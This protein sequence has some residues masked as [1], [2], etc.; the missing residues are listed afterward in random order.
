MMNR[1]CKAGLLT[2][3]GVT[4][5]AGCGLCGDRSPVAV[6]AVPRDTVPE[7][8]EAGETAP[9][10]GWLFSDQLVNEMAPAI[11]E[12]YEGNPEPG[13]ESETYQRPSLFLEGSSDALEAPQPTEWETRSDSR[14]GAEWSPERDYRPLPA[15]EREVRAQGG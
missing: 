13:D 2:G 8:L 1:Q 4:V 14:D 12:H 7:H 6:I 15:T 10:S 11:R 9:F 5:L 3:V